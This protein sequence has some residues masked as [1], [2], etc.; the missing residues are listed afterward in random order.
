[1][2]WEE[3]SAGYKGMINIDGEI[4]NLPER[5]VTVTLV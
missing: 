3:S 1:M 5:N 2:S 4:T